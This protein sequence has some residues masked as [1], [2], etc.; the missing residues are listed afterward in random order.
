MRWSVQAACQNA[1]IG[2]KGVAMTRLPSFEALRCDALKHVFAT[3]A[4]SG[5][6]GTDVAKCSGAV[7][8]PFKRSLDN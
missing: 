7:V 5:C 4:S 2:V 6:V 1:S 3:H 8:H